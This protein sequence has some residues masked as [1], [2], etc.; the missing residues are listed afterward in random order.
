MPAQRKWRFLS[1]V[2][3]DGSGAR[4]HWLV[5]SARSEYIGYVDESGSHSLVKVDPNY[6]IFVL[7][8]GMV[9]K[10]DYNQAMAPAIRR[11]KLEVFGY[12]MVIFREADI[13]RRRWAFAQLSQQGRE[14]LMEGLAG[15]IDTSSFTL[16]GAAI[17]KEK[18][19]DRYPKPESRYDLA[20]RFGLERICMF[21]EH[22]H[23][24]DRRTYGVCEVRGSREDKGS[25][26]VFRRICAGG[27]ALCRPLRFELVFAF[28]KTNSAGL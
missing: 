18:L 27:S 26:L 7:P 8:L 12:D 24:Q 21:L 13:R 17:D 6:P 22:E 25:E 3:S 15:I 16:A 23:Q 28:K 19:P 1:I 5:S 4:E 2:G 20:L 14:D 10:E 9:H 11:P